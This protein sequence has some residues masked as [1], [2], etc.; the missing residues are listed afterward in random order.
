M[1]AI[2]NSFLEIGGLS[3]IVFRASVPRET[4]PPRSH[5]GIRSSIAGFLT[6]TSF[7]IVCCRNK[8][9]EGV[10]P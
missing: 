9:K 2:A 3:S 5:V 6:L 7:I 10:M 1:D 4:W 8:W